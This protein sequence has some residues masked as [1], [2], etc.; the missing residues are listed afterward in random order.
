MSKRLIRFAGV[1]VA[2]AVVATAVHAASGSA[3]PRGAAIDPLDVAAVPTRLVAS[4]QTVALARAGERVVAVGVRGLI[5]YSDDAGAH[6]RQASVPVSSDLVTV[7][8]VDAQRG[9]AGGHDGVILRSDDGGTTWTK[10]YD[11]RMA[12]KQ[13]V[14]HFE[15]RSKAGDPQAARLLEEM[16]RNYAGG[17]EQPVLDLWFETPERG[18]AVGGFGTLL[19]TEDGG[20]TWQSW[21]ERV[22]VDQMYHYNAIRGFGGDVYIA[23]ERG[24]L[25]K[26]DRTR[27]RFALIETGYKG[28]YFGLAG[29]PDYVVA[30][31]LRGTAYRSRDRGATWSKLDVGVPSGLTGGTVLAD[32]S[33]V[34]VTQDG[35]LLRSTDQ[36]DKF[37]AVSGVRPTMLTGVAP[38]DPKR[39]VLS[40]L[41]GVQTVALP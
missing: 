3:A 34:L 32:G 26:L 18:W 33:L 6:W 19:G 21:V 2:T 16:K 22:D 30:F 1:W 9:W 38:V 15:Q 4:T 31:G 7:T 27:G 12:A 25:F 36:G 41:S 10:Q 35:R 8:F 37:Q 13:L 23:S 28:S 17:P 11:G 24:M 20:R 29:T 14:A 40:G 5:V 39:L